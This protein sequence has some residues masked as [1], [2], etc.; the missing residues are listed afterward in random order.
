MRETFHLTRNRRMFLPWKGTANITLNIPVKITNETKM[1]KTL[2]L[3][4]LR[5]LLIPYS[6]K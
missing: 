4:N 2:L 3:A 6:K 5:A 1:A